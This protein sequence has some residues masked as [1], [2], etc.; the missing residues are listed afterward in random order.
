[1]DNVYI[2]AGM[3]ILAVVMLLLYMNRRRRRKMLH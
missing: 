2:Q 1:M 3:W